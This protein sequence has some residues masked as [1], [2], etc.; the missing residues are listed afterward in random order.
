VPLREGLKSTI[1]YF[2]DLLNCSKT[3]H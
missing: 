2:D 1:A 3:D